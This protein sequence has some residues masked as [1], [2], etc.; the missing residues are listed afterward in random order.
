[1]ADSGRT[2]RIGLWVGLVGSL[3]IWLYEYVLLYKLFHQGNDAAGVVQHA[4]LLV[5]GPGM[6]SSGLPGFVLGLLIHCATGMVWGVVFAFIWQFL[7]KPRIEA[8]LAALLFGAIAWAVTHL[9]VLAIFST[10]PPVYTTYGVINGLTSHM[11]AFA[12]PMAL[13]VKTLGRYR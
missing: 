7:T 1:M 4:A 9:V 10:E 8:T 6:R 11:V 3:T 12:V 2:L 5:F 13:T